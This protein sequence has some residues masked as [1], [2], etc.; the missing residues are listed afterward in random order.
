[1]AECVR[2][3]RQESER[4]RVRGVLEAI[5]MTAYDGSP[6]QARHVVFEDE[7]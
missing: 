3:E 6:L 1:M 2:I 4:D 7:R 5:P